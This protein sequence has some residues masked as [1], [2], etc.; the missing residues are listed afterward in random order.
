LILL[1]MAEGEKREKSSCGFTL[2]ELLVVI[3]LM[4]LIAGMVVPR[5]AG[6]LDRM[7]AR[8]AA[9]K[10]S[11][12]L[13]YARSQAAAEQIPYVAFLDTEENAI[14]IGPLPREEASGFADSNNVSNPAMRSFSPPRGVRFQWV[15]EAENRFSVSK[16]TN[17]ILF[18]P[19]GGASGGRIR[20]SDEDGREYI[21]SVDRL[22]GLA[23]VIDG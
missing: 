2:L 8:T 16:E 6:S 18:F 15:S 1:E 9:R 21:L 7:N 22:T 11:A 14:R 4:S 10:V 5:M 17:E 23:E 13:R 3:A 12:A 19:S 20:L